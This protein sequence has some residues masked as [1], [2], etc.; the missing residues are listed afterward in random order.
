MNKTRWLPLLCGLIGLSLLAGCGDSSDDG[1][2]PPPQTADAEADVAADG[3]PAD[4][5]DAAAD[6]GKEAGP[7]APGGDTADGGPKD[8]VPEATGDTA[9]DAAPD[10][11]KDTPAELAPDA[12]AEAAPEAAPDVAPEVAP[13]AAPDVAPEVAPE[14][15]PDVAQDTKPDAAP[16]VG[17]D[18]KPD[19][20][21]DAAQ[22]AKPDAT[23]A[24]IDVADAKADTADAAA[25]APAVDGG[26]LNAS[27]PSQPV[28]LIFI[29]H[30]T[31]ENWLNDSNGGLGVALRNNNYYVSDTNYGWGPSGIGNTTDI[32]HWYLWFRGPNAATF[33]TALFGESGQHCSYSRLATNPGG[34]NEVVLFK[35]C[36]PNSALKGSPSDPVPAIG[37]NPLRGQDAYSAAHTVANAKGI[38]I[39][40]LE[41]FKT[42]QDKLFVVVAAPPLQSATYSS[43][44][45]AFN[46]WLYNDWLKGY[47]YNNVAVLD[48]YNV[49]TTN[50]GNANTNDLGSASGNHHR[51]IG[52]AIQH[53]IDGDNDS[54]PNVLEYPTGD[55]HPSQAGNL[56]ATAELVP[57]LNIAY[58]R[59][60]G[61]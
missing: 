59:W 30:S 46:E 6:R 28:R 14:A 40:A 37:S 12:P 17:P 49:L 2:T 22:D 34:Q 43:N 3:A 27:P 7:D 61:N 57:L 15:A 42:R 52:G 58:H 8:A 47:A 13:E 39:D 53:K 38:Y 21:P 36:F 24:G 56:K 35:S 25:D 5:R 51:Y 1:G 55:D 48:F 16:D 31:G 60:K 33:M 10:V 50:G 26:Q 4:V 9:K 54:N 20:A 11:P 41:Y 45:R 19:A 18:T 44:A 29:H 32:G 23:D